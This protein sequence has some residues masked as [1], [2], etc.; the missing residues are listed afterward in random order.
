MK[1][2]GDHDI[3]KNTIWSAKA[4]AASTNYAYAI[5][6]DGAEFSATEVGKLVS[7]IY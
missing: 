1:L 6:F 4:G 5:V 7:E 2:A 3:V